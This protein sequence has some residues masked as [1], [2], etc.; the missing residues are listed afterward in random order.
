MSNENNPSFFHSLK[1]RYGLGLSFFLVVAGYFLWTEHEAHV[2]T[3]LPYAL[4]AGC[5]IMHLFMHGGH[6]GHGDSGGGKDDKPHGSHD[7]D[8]GSR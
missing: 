4:V 5:L 7:H 1:F 3:A 6:G 2:I 8:G